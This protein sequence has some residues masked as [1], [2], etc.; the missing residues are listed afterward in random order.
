MPLPQGWEFRRH[1][2]PHFLDHNTRTS[3]SC[4]FVSF[5]IFF[6]AAAYERC[7]FSNTGRACCRNHF[8]FRTILCSLVILISTYL[9]M[10]HFACVGGCDVFHL[11]VPLFRRIPGDPRPLPEGWEQRVRKEDGVAYF[12]NHTARTTQWHHPC[13]QKNAASIEVKVDDRGR[14]CVHTLSF[15]HAR[16]HSCVCS[17]DVSRF[18]SQLL[19][20]S[21]FL[22][23][24][25]PLSFFLSF[26]PQTCCV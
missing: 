6:D 12:I 13:D 26:R 21:L 11:W 19:F 7:A 20:L 18:L 4:A 25:L 10:R 14:T 2:K 3:H 8:F 24:S 16:M 5:H 23:P 1:P 17:W 9:P 22:L 15:L